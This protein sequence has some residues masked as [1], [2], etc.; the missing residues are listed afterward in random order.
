MTVQHITLKNQ[1]RE[2]A[3]LLISALRDKLVEMGETLHREQQSQSIGPPTERRAETIATLQ[4]Q[5]DRL[6]TTQ[7]GLQETYATWPAAPVCSVEA[8]VVPEDV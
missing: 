2:D 7:S 5:Y 1:T 8:V 4:Q 6:H 3:R